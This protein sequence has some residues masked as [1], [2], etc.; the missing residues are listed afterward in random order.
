MQDESVKHQGL[1]NVKK[2]KMRYSAQM[3]Q[4]FLMHLLNS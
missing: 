1:F 4:K 2:L 3:Y